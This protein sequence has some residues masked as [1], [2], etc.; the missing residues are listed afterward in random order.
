MAVLKCVLLAGTKQTHIKGFDIICS[1]KYH[2][3][4]DHVN[5]NI[6]IMAG[7]P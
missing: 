2:A 6:N 3:K 1:C 4:E 5:L 7:S